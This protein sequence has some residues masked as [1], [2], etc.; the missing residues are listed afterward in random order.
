MLI[1]P[2]TILLLTIP[3]GVTTAVLTGEWRWLLVSLTAYLLVR[4]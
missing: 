2:F 1:L 4:G 3:V